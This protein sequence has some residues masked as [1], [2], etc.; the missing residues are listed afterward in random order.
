MVEIDDDLPAA[1]ASKT[2]AD[3]ASKSAIDGASRTAVDCAN[4]H[5][6]DADEREALRLKVGSY[7]IWQNLGQCFSTFKPQYF[8]I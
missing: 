7:E 1:Y 8:I 4:C 6:G 5:I 2:A 3:G